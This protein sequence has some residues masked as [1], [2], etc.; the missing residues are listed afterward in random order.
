MK[1]TLFMFIGIFFEDV[2]KI[3]IENDSYLYH[4]TLGFTL[5]D[6][7]LTDSYM[8]VGNILGFQDTKYIKVTSNLR[9]KK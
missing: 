9:F 2:K 5:Y 6:F 4:L 1:A 7:T 3:Y 8:S